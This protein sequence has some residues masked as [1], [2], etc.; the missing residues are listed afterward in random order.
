[1]AEPEGVAKAA[2]PEPVTPITAGAETGGVA[3]AAEP[4]EVPP[5]ITEAT[6]GVA[7]AEEERP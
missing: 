1:M 4:P 5:T 3:K 7:R 2:R 6:V